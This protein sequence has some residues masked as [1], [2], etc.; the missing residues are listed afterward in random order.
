MSKA[1]V[2]VVCV[3]KTGSKVKEFWTTG[4]SKE[5]GEKLLSVN[6][7]KL[8]YKYLSGMED[9]DT[10]AEIKN[11]IHDMASK[12]ASLLDSK[13]KNETVKLNHLEAVSVLDEMTVKAMFGKT[14]LA[15]AIRR[16]SG[17]EFPK[18]EKEV[19]DDGEE[20]TVEVESL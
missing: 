15:E 2:P 1:I 9:T 6:A 4:L 8:T 20:T 18:V 16:T 5:D 11:I 10:G 13:L 17:L 12:I 19:S 14:I 7:G 3:A